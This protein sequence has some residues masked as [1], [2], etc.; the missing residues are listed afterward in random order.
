MAQE[1]RAEGSRLRAQMGEGKDGAQAWSLDEHPPEKERG[2]SCPRTAPRQVVLAG[3]IQ[4]STSKMSAF[5]QPAFSY[6]AY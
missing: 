4:S 6:A 2:Q 5:R 3:D 1:N